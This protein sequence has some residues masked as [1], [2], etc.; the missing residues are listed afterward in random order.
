MTAALSKAM[1]KVANCSSVRRRMAHEGRRASLQV[2]V[3]PAAVYGFQHQ[4]GLFVALRV[5]PAMQ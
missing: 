3:R 4:R 5:G 1:F 2:S